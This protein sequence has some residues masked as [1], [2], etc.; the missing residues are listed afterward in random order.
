[1]NHPHELLAD[2]LDGTLGADARAEVDAHLATCAACRGDLAAAEVGRGAVGGL[3]LA[4]PP[5]DLR[6]RILAPTGARGG[7]GA[8]SPRWYRWA[9]AAA[10]AA[11]VLAVAVSLPGI[12]D[13]PAG[14]R[15]AADAAAEGAGTYGA[16]DSVP[17][18]VSGQDFRERDLE[19][20]ASQ[21]AGRSSA[22]LGAGQSVAVPANALDAAT[23]EEAQEATSCIAEAFAG[24]PNGR[25]VRLIRGRFE[26]RDAYVAIYLEGPGA[27]ADPDLAVVWAASATDCSVLSFA[28]ARL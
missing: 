11:I 9:G 2:L 24:Q 5:D 19:R 26:G 25:L 6:G 22:E 12:G 4:E 16:G 13:D 14:D 3:P 18:E 7:A 21:A 28:Q 20:L 1:M 8:G 15:A 10:A 17:L 27:G 23:E